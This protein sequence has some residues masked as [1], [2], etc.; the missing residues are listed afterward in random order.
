MSGKLFGKYRDVVIDNRDPPQMGRIRAKV[1]EVFGDA[2]S[3]WATPC[4]PC[5]VSK[6]I[7]SALPKIG[8][9]VWIEFEAGDVSRPVWAGCFWGA[10]DTPPSLRNK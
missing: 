2:D 6:I 7:G 1:P 4:L 3:G 9:G 5:N 8:A 10:D